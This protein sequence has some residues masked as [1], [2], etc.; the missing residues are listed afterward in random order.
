LILVAG[1]ATRTPADT[2]KP[3]NEEWAQVRPLFKL[4]E[5]VAAGKPAPSDVML[6][7]HCHFVNA[8]AGVVFVPFTLK[9][10]KGEFTSFPVAIY[11]RVVV[12]GAPAPAPGPGDA[13]AQYPFE[14]AAVIER[15][16]DGRMTRAF[17]APP[18]DYDVYV[19][20]REKPTVEVP[21]PKTVVL[22]EP[23]SVPDLNTGLAVSSIIVA[24]KIESD[25]RGRRADFEEQLDDPY[26]LWGS[27]IT[28]ALKNVFGR[29]KALSVVFLIYNTGAAGDDKPDVEVQYSFYRATSGGEVFFI[30]TKPERSNAE[31]LGRQFSLAAGDL[32]IAGREM[33]LTRFPDGDYRLEITVTDK[34]DGTSLTRDV[35]LTVAG[36]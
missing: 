1:S 9:I 2:R 15:P 35:K 17:T 7:W 8:Q 11:L 4:V 25:A 13:L 26:A 16:N 28:P 29:S 36:S 18:G 24:D 20:L 27:R 22:K 14:D 33:P 6:S 30:K 3:V 23:V 19:A 21:Q 12:R 32:I 31:T 10:E 5:E 34:T